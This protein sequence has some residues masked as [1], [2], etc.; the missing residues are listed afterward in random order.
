[1]KRRGVLVLT[2]LTVLITGLGMNS[3][4]WFQGKHSAHHSHSRHHARA[5]ASAMSEA[6]LRHLHFQPLHWRAMLLQR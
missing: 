6:A 3:A 5:Q 1:M 2:A 4:G